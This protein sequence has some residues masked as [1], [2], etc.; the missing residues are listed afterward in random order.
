MSLNYLE[1]QKIIDELNINGSTLQLFKAVDYDSFVFNFY[2][3]EENTFLMVGIGTLPRIHTITIKPEYLKSPHNLVEFFKANLLGATVQK[4][5]QPDSNRIIKITLSRDSITFFIFIRLWAGFSNIIITDSN[6]TILHLHKKSSKKNE[7][8]GELFI[9]PPQ[10]NNTKEY[11]LQNHNYPSYNSFIKNEYN[12]ISREI[13]NQKLQNKLIAERIKK[14]TEINKTLK[15]LYKRLKIYKGVNKYKLYG[16]LIL[17]NIHNI[18]KGDSSVTVQD[19]STSQIVNIPLDPKIKPD[20]NSLHYY[21]MY[22]KSQSG[23]DITQGQISKLEEALKNIEVDSN[24]L[25]IEIK[26]QKVIKTTPGLSYTYKEWSFLIGRNAKENEA[27]LRSW[28]K[29]NDIW[30]HVRDFPGGYLFIKNVKGKTIPLEILIIG[31]NLA[32]FYSKAKNSGK[33]DV[34][35]TQVKYLRRVKKGKPG[36]VIP[37]MDKNLFITLNKEILEKF[38][39]LTQT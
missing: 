23:L 18:K 29:G 17:S 7:Q 1:I 32:L 30:M 10:K 19:Y 34:M 13:N 8:P 3:K 20:E 11:S 26:Q 2:K 5:E 33:G 35:Y 21:K 27:L 6:N 14:E 4:I 36:E 31:A 24:N 22:K 37:S 25:G 38:R 15:G 9:I 12:R 28:V 16:D 39:T